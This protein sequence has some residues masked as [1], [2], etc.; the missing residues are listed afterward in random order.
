LTIRLAEGVMK[1]LKAAVL[2]VVLMALPAIAQAQT[3]NF[4]DLNT[5]PSA[6][7]PI[8]PVPQLPNGYHGFNWNNF[9]VLK[10]SRYFD[11]FLNLNTYCIVPGGFRNGVVSSPN[12][13]FNGFGA[14]ASVSSTNPF[15]FNSVYMTAGWN[16]GLNV[17]VQGF[18]GAS[19]RYSQ[20][21]VLNTYTPRLFAPNWAGVDKVLFTS[22]GGTNP[23][24]IGFGEHVVFDNMTMSPAVIPEP[25]TL[26]LLG[27]GLGLTGIGVAIR[28]RRRKTIES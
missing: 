11:P 17:L 20:S 18:L 23:G 1:R 19:L 13:A 26:L 21:L 4:D 14:P 15:T 3:I 7:N 28:R 6:T 8:C 9:Y 10:G 16:D 24:Y 27:T 2:G 25:A 22:S 5:S 12:V